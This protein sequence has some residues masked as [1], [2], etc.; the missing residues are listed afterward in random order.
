[1]L[2][3]RK[4]EREVRKALERDDF[5]NEEI[6]ELRSMIAP[7][8]AKDVVVYDSGDQDARS[9]LLLKRKISLEMGRKTASENQCLIN[10]PKC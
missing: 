2:T 3:S 7:V 8:E 9:D 10:V 1:M 5:S 6:K 4:I